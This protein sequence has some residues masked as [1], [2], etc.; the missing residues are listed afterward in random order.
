MVRYNGHLLKRVHAADECEAWAKV[1]SMYNGGPGWMP[2]DE[3]LAKSHGEDPLI[4]WGSVEKYSNR[5]AWAFKENRDYPLKIIRKHQVK[6]IEVGWSGKPV[7]MEDY[8]EPVYAS[9]SQQIAE[10]T[11]PEVESVESI[12]ARF[13]AYGRWPF[14]PLRMV[15]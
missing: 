6:Y 9:L 14:Y 11:L 7:C 10:V 13:V 5:A 2:R 12:F 4:W 8:R 1:L 3:A 15:D